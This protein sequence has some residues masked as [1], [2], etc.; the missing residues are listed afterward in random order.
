MPV[1]VPVAPPPLSTGGFWG[2]QEQMTTIWTFQTSIIA[3]LRE[4]VVAFPAYG[5]RHFSD[6]CHCRTG[7]HC[8]AEWL[9]RPLSPQPLADHVL[10]DWVRTGKSY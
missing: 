3:G 7:V 10:V 2:S 5:A 6:G 4:E 8:L 1:P 9:C